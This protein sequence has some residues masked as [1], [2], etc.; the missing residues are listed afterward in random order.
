MD[1]ECFKNATYS[2]KYKQTHALTNLMVIHS[3]AIIYANVMTLLTP[4]NASKWCDP[5]EGLL[6]D[7]NIPINW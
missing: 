7:Q 5:N 3:F 6:R 2:Q 1:I 4:F